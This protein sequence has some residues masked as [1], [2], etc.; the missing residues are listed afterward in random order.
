M[1]I[2]YSEYVPVFQ[3][4]SELQAVKYLKPLWDKNKANESLIY[5]SL[6]A[7]P[8]SEMDRE[9]VDR[10]TSEIQDKLQGVARTGAYERAGVTLMESQNIMDTDRGLQ[11]ANASY[12]VRQEEAKFVTEQQG[13][14]ND[15]LDFGAGMWKDHRSYYKDEE[16]GKMVEN[17]YSSKMEI[18][19]DYNKEMLSLVK[20]I[21]ADS[22]GV[23]QGKANNIAEGLIFNYISGEVGKQDYKRL[24]LLKYGDIEDEDERH[25][26]A[27]SDIRT[28]M[29]GVTNQYVHH[30]V[31]NN[32][33]TN[34]GLN[35]GMYS[36]YT[37]AS[38][39]SVDR[40]GSLLG[41][42]S[43]SSGMIDLFQES[44]SLRMQGGKENW[45]AAG[46]IEQQVYD[47][48]QYLYDNDQI[49]KEAY[50]KYVYYHKEV[51]RSGSVDDSDALGLLSYLTTEW[52]EN[53]DPD[54]TLQGG[55]VPEPWN[56]VKAGGVGGGVA[57]LSKLL[58]KPYRLGIRATA[59]YTTVGHLGLQ[60]GSTT[61]DDFSN[62]RTG[63]PEEGS[64][65]DVGIMGNELEALKN[66]FDPG[67]LGRV[68]DLLGK[69]LT[70]EDLDRLEQKAILMYHYKSQ[71]G[72][73]EVDQKLENYKGHRKENV[74]LIGDNNT[75]EGRAANKN[76]KAYLDQLR[77]GNFR[78]IGT[79]ETSS[80]YETITGE[81]GSNAKITGFGGL[82]DV[83]LVNN[84]RPRILGLVSN[85]EGLESEVELETPDLILKPGQKDVI[86]SMMEMQGNIDGVVLEMTRQNIWDYEKGGVYGNQRNTTAEQ[87]VQL[88]YNNSYAYQGDNVPEKERSDKASKQVTDIFLN[89]LKTS[90]KY[91]G[92]FSNINGQYQTAAAKLQKGQPVTLN[93]KPMKTKMQLDS[94]YR[95]QENSIMQFVRERNETI[96]R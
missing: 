71:L 82:S 63:R 62:V 20:L 44:L 67:N 38:N 72:G 16:T 30:K 57:W 9:H 4:R 33:N 70:V 17:V 40:G 26:Q 64:S 73:D 85:H 45:E 55:V 88:V 66:I 28:R 81:D 37:V 95:S 93:G 10:V 90:N 36:E 94:W 31:V 53:W 41:S 69:K 13:K 89:Y 8:T 58:P 79:P 49:T 51:L 83:D 12:A 32:S 14:G 61:A 54:Y 48:V 47:N 43:E 6:S 46:E 80:R 21:K 87:F 42:N 24:M 1:A 11:L 34:L 22:S 18:Q 23:S 91:S 77:I 92:H 3:D 15:V 5:K 7:I 52:G 76:T 59:L 74:F 50:D 86:M 68:S 35:N 56:A 60:A 29:R 25:Q 84:I 65:A 96:L 19:E 78:I 75:E 27:I 39:M 2:Q